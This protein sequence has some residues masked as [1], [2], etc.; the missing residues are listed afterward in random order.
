M[1]T[2]WSH[3]E[4]HIKVGGILKEAVFG[5]ND[6]VVSTFAVVAGMTGGTVGQKTIL[7]AALATLVAGAFS[8]GLGT[9]LGSKFEKDHY[10]KELA[11]EKYEMKY[12]P[13][14]EKQEIRDIFAAKGFK[15]DLLEKIVVQLADNPKIWLQTMMTEELG[16]A[17][18]PPKPALNGITM[19]VAFTIGSLFPTLPYFLHNNQVFEPFG[20]PVIFIIS[21][22]LSIIGLLLAGSSKTYF[23]GRNIFISALETLIVGAIA[24]VG[25]YGIGI[26]LA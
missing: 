23:T 13:E 10:E 5:F 26:L 6:G 16:F 15:G 9:Y 8:M 4:K 11:R 3:G 14:I 18:S 22:G 20:L 24:A 21:L 17:G 2:Y 1:T 12:L 19:S 7:L 25:T